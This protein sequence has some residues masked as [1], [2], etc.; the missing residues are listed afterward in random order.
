M[1]PN[2]SFTNR[3][4]FKQGLEKIP[5]EKAYGAELSHFFKPYTTN[6]SKASGTAAF[7]APVIKIFGQTFR[8]TGFYYGTPSGLNPFGK[9]TEYE[10]IIHGSGLGSNMEIN[11]SPDDVRTFGLKAPSIFVGWGFDQFGYPAPNY[12]SGYAISG[13][14][15]SVA[16]SSGFLGTGNLPTFHGKNVPT[17]NFLAGPIDLRWDIHRKVWSTPQNV[18]S[19]KIVYAFYVEGG[20]ILASG[21]A[22]PSSYFADTLHYNAMITDGFANQM[23]LTGITLSG[24]QPE[25]NTYKVKPLQSGTT[26][27]ILHEPGPRYG[28]WCWHNPYTTDCNNSPQSFQSEDSGFDTFDL[29]GASNEVLTGASLISTLSAAPLSDDYGGTGWDDYE[30]MDILVGRKILGTGTL[31]KYTLVAGTGIGI[32]VD[33]SYPTGE[34]VVSLGTGISI[35]TNGVNSDITELAGLTTPLTIAQGGTGQSVK[36][37]VDLTTAQSVGGIKCFYS[38]IRVGTGSIIS[39]KYSFCDYP[40]FG[41]SLTSG[42]YQYSLNTSHSGILKIATF[43]T[44]TQFYDN[45]VIRNNN[46]LSVDSPFKVFAPT[47]WGYTDVSGNFIQNSDKLSEWYDVSGRMCFYIH[48]SGKEIGFGPS[49][50]QTRLIS[51]A[52]SDIDIYLPNATGTIALLSDIVA[53]TGGIATNPGGSTSNIQYNLSGSF[54]GSNN[55]IWLSGSNKL[56][57][58]GSIGIKAPNPSALLHL[59][60]G[61]DNIPPILFTSGALVSSPNDGMMEYDGGRL[62]FVPN[63]NI[64]RSQIACYGDYSSLSLSSDQNDLYIPDGTNTL[65]ISSTSN[66]TVNGLLLLNPNGTHINVINVGSR[67]IMFSH[68]DTN[69]SSSNRI[70]MPFELPM[71]LR[72]GDAWGFKYDS[73][74]QKWI[75]S[76]GYNGYL[77]DPRYCNTFF[78]DFI[79]THTNI[80]TAATASNG[81]VTSANMTGYEPSFGIL[82]LYISGN[83]ASRATLRSTSAFAIGS[84]NF[85]LEGDVRFNTLSDSTNRYRYGF[86]LVTAS[87]TD[88]A[89]ADSIM[90]NYN[91]PSGTTWIART[92]R[93]STAINTSGVATVALVNHLKIVYNKLPNGTGI[94]NY[95]VN[96]TGIATH[97]GALNIP[98]NTMLLF[99]QTLNRV[100]GAP[101][102]NAYHDF[103]KITRMAT[104]VRY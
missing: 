88:I 29:L 11:I 48:T 60:S 34:I 66:I 94:V 53:G 40:T 17:E 44:G 22:M 65:R 77:N 54:A 95:Y 73:T 58:N 52:T 63:S 50:H 30:D 79:Q 67:P 74:N 100:A 2:F 43:A 59:G 6:L 75:L 91:G 93:G 102:A 5:Y 85:I 1:N 39:P 64:G 8:P 19:A 25:T 10:G 33:L 4:G 35:S 42:H 83:V 104:G 87:T 72:P 9:Y 14:L 21:T 86:G 76:D 27:L 57:V 61:T 38:G 97:S 41:W 51:Q 32:T 70:L 13:L 89:P 46:T 20:Q 31:G 82:R 24:P 55:L 3:D 90:L 99:M 26:A 7:E 37:F 96:G 36:S 103:I 12:I 98:S 101:R 47:T 80:Y 62:T 16:P 84:E 23:M 92:S 45:V 78:E 69:A 18:F 28:L 81:L 68:N 71:V 56:E 49:G 15:Q